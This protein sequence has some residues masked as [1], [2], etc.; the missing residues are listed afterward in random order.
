[1]RK[2]LSIWGLE[3]SSACWLNYNVYGWIYE[4]AA[5]KSVMRLDWQEK[6]GL[7]HEEPCMSCQ[8]AKWWCRRY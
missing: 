8:L 6:L 2:T 7:E 1:M 3:D 4:E 5:G